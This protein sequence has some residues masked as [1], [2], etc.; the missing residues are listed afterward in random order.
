MFL[1]YY[2]TM[3]F[4]FLGLIDFSVRQVMAPSFVDNTRLQSFFFSFPLFP[5]DVDA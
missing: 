5:S 2:L 3:T 4:H 1:F